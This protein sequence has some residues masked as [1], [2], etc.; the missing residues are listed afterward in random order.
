MVSCGTINGSGDNNC[1][2]NK[3]DDVVD[4]DGVND[5]DHLAKVVVL[6]MKTTTTTNMMGLVMKMMTKMK[7]TMATKNIVQVT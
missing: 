4:D 3:N 1:D 2:C 7:A 5:D 6:I